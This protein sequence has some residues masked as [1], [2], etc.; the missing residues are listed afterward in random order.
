MCGGTRPPSKP[1]PR[2]E[3]VAQGSLS[4]LAALLFDRAVALT[5]RARG[6]RVILYAARQEPALLEGPQGRT[7]GPDALHLPRRHN[8][9]V[10]ALFTQPK[11]TRMRHPGAATSGPNKCLVEPGQRINPRPEPRPTA[12]FSLTASLGGFVAQGSLS[13][14]AA[15]PPRRGFDGAGHGNTDYLVCGAARTRTAGRAAGPDRRPCATSGTPPRPSLSP[16]PR[17]NRGKLQRGSTHNRDFHPAAPGPNR[18]VVEPGRR[19]N[20]R[21]EPRPTTSFRLAAPTTS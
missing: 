21:P 20:P 5:A 13:S 9:R 1:V 7:A 19:I 16:S 14:L 4:S 15:F 11:G 17:I 6:I 10:V 18:C 2:E 3:Y 12:S 8:G